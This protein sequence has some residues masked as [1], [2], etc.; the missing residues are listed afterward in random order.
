MYTIG[1]AQYA[2]AQRGLMFSSEHIRKI[3]DRELSSY[4]TYTAGG[5][6]LVTREGL[7]ALARRGR[8]RARR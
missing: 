1:E 7:D 4:V 6:R 5:I 2:L 3:F 8:L